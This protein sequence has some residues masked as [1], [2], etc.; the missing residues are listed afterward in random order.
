MWRTMM[1]LW[2]LFVL[3]L[4]VLLSGCMTS[5]QQHAADEE[6]CHAY[7]YKKRNDAFAECMQ[8]LDLDRRARLRNGPYVDGFAGG[9]VVIF[10]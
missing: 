4:T 3:A 1:R 10:D 8:R 5:E 6:R 7:G 2:L 9:A